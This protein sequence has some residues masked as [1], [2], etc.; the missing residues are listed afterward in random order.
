MTQGARHGSV[1]V[2][3]L[4]VVAAVSVLTLSGVAL[5]RALHERAEIGGQM[6]QARRLAQSGAELAIHGSQSNPDN[7]HASALDGVVLPVTTLGGGS[8]VVRVRDADTG[9]DPTGGTTRFRVVSEAT[10]DQ[11]RSR[12]GV[13]LTKPMDEMTEAV[14]ALGAIAYWALDEVG[15][16]TAVDS[17]NGRNGTYQSP[18][19]A[20]ADTHVHGNPAPRMDWMTEAVSVPH[21]AAFQTA[22][23]TVA[24]WVR[25]DLMP[26][27]GTQF[28]AVVKERPTANSSI[29]LAFWIDSSSLSFKL[30]NSTNQ[31]DTLTCSASKITPGQWHFIAGTWGSAGM[32]F[33]LDGVL[34]DSSRKSH[35]LNAVL[36]SRLANT[37]DW[38]FGLRNQPY[39]SYSQFW[40]T[41]GSVARVSLFDRGLTESEVSRLYEA[42]T[43]K[44][45]I[46]IEEGS[47]ARV[48]D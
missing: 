4:A 46:E 43:I 5:R 34:V 29:D 27:S 17:L 18:A 23:G 21:N 38:Y 26:V 33:Y 3:V 36:L 39:G 28:G 47:F 48:T 22:S 30:E 25:F 9:A 16:T 41:Y 15:S 45:L 19:S 44:G 12:L 42:S 7:F 14:T 10:Q 11:A 37:Q 6:S 20:G 24:F 40:P 8:L 32:N 1:Y 13:T 35:G 31:G 2:A